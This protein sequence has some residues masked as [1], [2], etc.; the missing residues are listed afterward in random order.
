MNHKQL[1]DFALQCSLEHHLCNVD[2]LLEE[3]KT[4]GEILE[5]VEQNR[6]D[7]VIWEPFEYYE[8]ASL[9]EAI[10]DL[11]GVYYYNFKQVLKMANGDEWVKDNMK[12]EA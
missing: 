8:P 5:M 10:E 6:D 1:R 3:G 9:V 2:E 7:V 4:L 12:D 11:R